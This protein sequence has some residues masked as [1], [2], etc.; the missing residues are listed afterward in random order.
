[1]LKEGK[2][3]PTN[4]NILWPDSGEMPLALTTCRIKAGYWRDVVCYVGDQMQLLQCARGR[5][6]HYFVIILV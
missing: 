2:M 1:M 5:C 3:K 6:G 4:T